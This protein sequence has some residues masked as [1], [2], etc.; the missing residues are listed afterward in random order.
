MISPRICT[1]VFSYC[2]GTEIARRHLPLWQSH[3]D[4]VILVY[5]EDSPSIV[6]GVEMVAFG[7]SN[8]YGTEC[9]SRQLNGMRYALHH[10][11]DY[12]VFL[13]YDAFLLR[14][15]YLRYGIQANV[16]YTTECEF[17]T[18]RYYHFPWIFDAASLQYFAATATLEPFEKGFVD[19]WV[20][21][22]TVSMNM[23]WFDL[24]A[25]GEGYSRNTIRLPGEIRD[26]VALAQKGAY[27]FHG[28]KTAD[29]FAQIV[30]ASGVGIQQSRE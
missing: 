23:E 17:H 6:E 29:L 15:P 30:N 1:T 27:A 9:L 7:K 26:A 28:V 5:P 18:N 8:K 3:S 19:R 22:Q 25:A 12:Y 20:A 16:F 4:S 14:R 10:Q 13:E 2:G 21:A 24:A 11:A